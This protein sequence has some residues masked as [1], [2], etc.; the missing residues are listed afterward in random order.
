[1]NASK[2]RA[3]VDVKD[4]VVRVKVGNGKGKIVQICKDSI[5]ADAF[6]EGW[7]LSLKAEVLKNMSIRMAYDVGSIARK[8]GRDLE[9]NPFKGCEESQDKF[10]SWECGF[11]HG[12]DEDDSNE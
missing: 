11:R 12:C 8:E 7:N 1:M 2:R 6:V 5:Q 10:W 9:D 3:Y 4:G